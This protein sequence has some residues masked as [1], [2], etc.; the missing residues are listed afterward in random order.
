M[1]GELGLAVLVEDRAEFVAA[2]KA[3]LDRTI[4]MSRE[5]LKEAGLEPSDITDVVLVGGSAR[6]PYV[7]QQLRELFPGREPRA[8][9]NPDDAVAVGAALY[10]DALFRSADSSAL[11]GVR[12]RDVTSLRHAARAPLHAFRRP[13][14]AASRA[15]NLPPCACGLA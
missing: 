12:L 14:P 6:I 15:C 11:P 7:Q 8:D 2:N 1:A 13:L 5:A 10:A 3:Y 4:S 9:V